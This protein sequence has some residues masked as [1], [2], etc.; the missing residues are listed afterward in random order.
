M[1]NIERLARFVTKYGAKG[2]LIH[3][4]AGTTNWVIAQ[5]MENDKWMLTMANPMGNVTYNLG[6]VSDKQHLE[7]WVEL[8]RLEIERKTNQIILAKQLKGVVNN[9]IKNYGQNYQKFTKIEKVS[10]KKHRRNAKNS[11]SR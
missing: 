8:T 3:T 9:F 6:V 1:K 4:I 7:L 2:T 5:K 11:K 10:V